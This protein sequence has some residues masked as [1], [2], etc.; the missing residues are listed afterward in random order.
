MSVILAVLPSF[1]L[2]Y[3]DDDDDDDDV[4]VQDSDVDYDVGFDDD[5]SDSYLTSCRI[6]AITTW[7]IIFI[8]E[9]A[10]VTVIM[11]EILITAFIH[12]FW[13]HAKLNKH[14][15]DLIATIG[16][17]C[18]CFCPPTMFLSKFRFAFSQHVGYFL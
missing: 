7:N 13:L 10:I 3:D 15:N 4:D 5:N 16:V 8:K 18:Q 12:E 11:P 14:D 6:D 2:T 1:N 17:Y 9:T